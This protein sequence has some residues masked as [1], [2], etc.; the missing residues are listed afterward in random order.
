[1]QIQINLIMSDEY[2]NKENNYVYVRP[3]YRPIR[4]G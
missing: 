2:S 4:N 1:M 3:E